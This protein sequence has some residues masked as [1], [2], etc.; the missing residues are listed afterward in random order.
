MGS[1]AKT[2]SHCKKLHCKSESHLEKPNRPQPDCGKW[3]TVQNMGRTE[4]HEL[5]CKKMGRTVKTV[6]ISYTV[7]NLVTL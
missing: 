5:P 7:K 6:K 4:K 3:V 2:G 1:T